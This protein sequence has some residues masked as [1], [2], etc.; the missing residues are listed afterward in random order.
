MPLQIVR[1]NREKVSGLKLLG[2]APCGTLFPQDAGDPPPEFNAK[3]E[4]QGW[5]ENS[6]PFITNDGGCNKKFTILTGSSGIPT[7]A[8]TTHPAHPAFFKHMLGVL[9]WKGVF[10][11]CW[12]KWKLT[13]DVT[14]PFPGP[15]LTFPDNSFELPYHTNRMM[16]P[17]AAWSPDEALYRDLKRGEP[18]TVPRW[19]GQQPRPWGGGGTDAKYP[20]QFFDC[21]RYL[22]CQF[23]HRTYMYAPGPHEPPTNNNWEDLAWPKWT[24]YKGRELPMD[25]SFFAG[26]DPN[27]PLPHPKYRGGAPFR[28]L[29]CVVNIRGEV[30]P[31]KELRGKPLGRDFATLEIADVG[32]AIP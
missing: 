21:R 11:S 32:L 3:L 29:Y 12:T 22:F 20:P 15:G 17:T 7:R 18:V 24:K 26:A 13:V 2:V 8:P 10:Q 30:Y 16:A 23:L 1:Q 6:L 27:E 19:W 4:W 25:T 5:D 9:M 14:D 31:N 28:P